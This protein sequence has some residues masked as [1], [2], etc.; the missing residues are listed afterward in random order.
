LARALPVGVAVVSTSGVSGYRDR[1]ASASG[2]AA[3]ISPK[4]TACNQMVGA[5]LI[6]CPHPK[7]SLNACQ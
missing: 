7:R 3:D 6:R 1:S 2:A 4:L 5:A